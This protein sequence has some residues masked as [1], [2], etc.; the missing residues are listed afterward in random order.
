MLL[1]LLVSVSVVVVLV[2]VSAT[3]LN[4]IGVWI[5]RKQAVRESLIR[6]E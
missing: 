2:V 1:L 5:G 4:K 3:D 6:Q